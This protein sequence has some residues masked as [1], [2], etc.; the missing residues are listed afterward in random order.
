MSRILLR[1][2]ATVSLRRTPRKRAQPTGPSSPGTDSETQRVS[3][4]GSARGTTEAHPPTTDPQQPG[5]VTPNPTPWSLSSLHPKVPVS[6]VAGA[7][8]S[9]VPSTAPRSPGAHAGRLPVE[10]Y[11][12]AVVAHVPVHHGPAERGA[13]TA[14]SFSASIGSALALPENQR[15]LSTF[16]NSKLTSGQLRARGEMGASPIPTQSPPAQGSSLPVLRPAACHCSNPPGLLRNPAP[17]QFSAV[18]PP[19]GPHPEGRLHAGAG[20]IA[21]CAGA[22][23]LQIRSGLRLD[24]LG[25]TLLPVSAP[26]WHR[27]LC[28]PG[29]SQSC[30]EH[31]A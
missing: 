25:Q 14:R 29:H 27:P 5:R 4:R 2:G 6:G 11:H 22:R 17:S 7:G 10:K 15:P 23:R 26:T 20:A 31:P 9:N 12:P 19:P 18:L 28:R 1:A 21:R 24:P 16:L 3:L 8:R 30:T 13:H